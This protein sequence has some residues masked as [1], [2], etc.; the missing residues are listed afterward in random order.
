MRHFG[1]MLGAWMAIAGCEDTRTCTLVECTG[2]PLEIALVDEAGAPVAARGELRGLGS[3]EPARFDCLD[4]P[5]GS[6]VEVSC[7][8]GLLPPF[9]Y[10]LAPD[11]RV[12][13]RFALADG[14]WTEWKRL[15]LDVSSHTDPDFNGPGCSCTWL[16]ATT[17]PVVA[18]AAARIT[19]GGATAAPRS[20]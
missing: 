6:E 2:G 20:G 10:N 4:D 14:S 17:P 19:G 11:T 3:V 9:V 18:P 15:D 8:D 13:L 7:D 16:E 5:R 1:W 12:G